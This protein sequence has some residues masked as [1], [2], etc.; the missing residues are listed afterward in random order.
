M[1]KRS[2]LNSPCHVYSECWSMNHELR[3]LALSIR[4]PDRWVLENWEKISSSQ[5]L[6]CF[7]M[8][9]S[10]PLTLTFMYTVHFCTSIIAQSENNM[11]RTWRHITVIGT[12]KWDRLQRTQLKRPSHE[13]RKMY[14][15]KNLPE[16]GRCEM[17]STGNNIDNNE[18]MIHSVT[19]ISMNSMGRTSAQRHQ[20]C[21]LS[22]SQ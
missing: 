7:L 12:I 14:Y 6:L 9:S 11:Y 8:S 22:P 5:Q 2:F 10:C 1:R 4:T 20:D 15:S 3:K 17:S 16:T 18:Y 19:A 21:I 13:M